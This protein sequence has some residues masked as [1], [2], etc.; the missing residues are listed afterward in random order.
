MVRTG[1]VQV[2]AG[3]TT[4][5]ASLAESTS[6]DAVQPQVSRARER[7]T[8]RRHPGHRDPLGH[9]PASVVASPTPVA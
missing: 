2:G 6:A 5:V 1:E 3:G 4:Y 9:R 8:S 7:S